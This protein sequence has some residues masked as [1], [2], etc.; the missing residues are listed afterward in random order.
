VQE[1][2]I[3]TTTQTYTFEINTGV[4]AV[5]SVNGE[6][7]NVQLTT[8]FQNIIIGNIVWVLNAGYF[9]YTILNAEIDATDVCNI[10]PNKGYDE[11]INNAEIQPDTKSI[12]GGC[13]WKKLGLC[14]KIK[15]S[16]INRYYIYNTIKSY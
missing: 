6:V 14:Y 11:I 9:E 5:Y 10:V 7:G 4:S 12:A 2:I 16:F 8:Q 15:S 1:L 3:N 13:E